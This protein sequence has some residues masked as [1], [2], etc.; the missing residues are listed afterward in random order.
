MKRKGEKGKGRGETNIK[1]EKPGMVRKRKGK[2]SGRESR[3]GER[4]NLR[5]NEN[6]WGGEE[7]GM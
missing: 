2:G 3:G 1:V 5:D 7:K 4:G 6:K